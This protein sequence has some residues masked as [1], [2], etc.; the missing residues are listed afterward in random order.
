MKELI[1]GIVTLVTIVIVIGLLFSLKACGSQSGTMSRLGG[2]AVLLQ[3]PSDCV[4]IINVGRSKSTKYV[5][6]LSIDGEI[7]MK[8]FSDYGVFEATYVLSGKYDKDLKETK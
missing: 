5:T 1:I 3:V 8:E 7:V 6:Y 4:Q 2:D